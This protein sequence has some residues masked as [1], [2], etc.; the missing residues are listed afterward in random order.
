LINNNYNSS[1]Y[2]NINQYT[3]KKYKNIF[4]YT[5]WDV[6]NVTDM[7]AMFD[8]ATSFNQP[9]DKWN[10]SNVKM[11]GS[12]FDGAADFDQNIN[13]KTV[14]LDDG[15]TYTAWDISKLSSNLTDYDF[16]DGFPDNKKP[17]T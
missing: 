10:T 15:T 16:P 2:L 3:N 8:D 14:T 9:L 17:T 12:I 13:T 5:A 11:M 7:G 1:Y 4:I 6:S